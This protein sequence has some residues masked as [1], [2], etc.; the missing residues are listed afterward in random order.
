MQDA[1][2]GGGDLGHVDAQIHLRKQH[3]LG[4][5]VRIDRPAAR[6]RKP[7]IALTKRVHALARIGAPGKRQREAVPR[8]PIDPVDGL[9]VGV[10]P[11][12]LLMQ[13]LAVMIEAHAQHELVAMRF[14][15]RE[16]A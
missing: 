11:A 2:A 10:S 7:P 16:Q 1:P 5:I 14:A 8:Q 13:R 9:V 3:E 4:R 6:P 12:L 15:K